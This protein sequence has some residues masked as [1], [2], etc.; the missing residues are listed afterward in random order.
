[1]QGKLPLLQSLSDVP[2][3]E[4]VIT[5]PSRL[6]LG[7]TRRVPLKIHGRRY[8]FAMDTGANFSVI[9]RSEAIR[10]G[11]E[12]RQA[13][14]VMPDEMLTFEGG[15]TIPG[16]VGFPL[17]EAMGEVRFR[18]DDVLEIPHPAPRRSAGNL[19]LHDLD[20]LVRVRY[21]K[22][23]LL[24]RLDTGAGQTVFYEPFF[25]RYQDRI[26]SVGKS[27]TATNT[28]VGGAQEVPAF[29]LPRMAFTVASAGVNLRR[30]EVYTVPIRPADQNF[31]YCNLGL[32]ALEQPRFQAYVLNFRDMALVLE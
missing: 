27:V 12:I 24:C 32:D 21:G 9:M 14:L 23:D 10:L 30:V 26:E 6:A 25:R 4:T 17:V 7:A 20:P 18:R 11:L 3:Q 28:G 15:H 13:D 19:T 5:G 16:L 29:R 2:P 22:D 31:L 1:M 8:D